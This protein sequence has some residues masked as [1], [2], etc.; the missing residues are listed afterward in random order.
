MPSVLLAMALLLA[1]DD[2][3]LE[4]YRE[5]VGPMTAVLD[6][7]PHRGWYTI[8]GGVAE[9][10]GLRG[11]VRSPRR[12]LE[13]L[14]LATGRV[15]WTA[16][17][18]WVP[19]IALEG[20]VLVAEQGDTLHSAR[21]LLVVSGEV[22]ERSQDFDLELSVHPSDWRVR[23]VAHSEDG[24]EL[25]LD[26]YVPSPVPGAM[27]GDRRRRLSLRYDPG[28]GTVAVTPVGVDP[29]ARG[30]LPPRTSRDGRV[31]VVDACEDRDGRPGREHCVR[32][33]V[34]VGSGVIM[35]SFVS[36]PGGN[37]NQWGYSSFVGGR[38]FA[39]GETPDGATPVREE[40]T[41]QERQRMGQRSIAILPCW[42]VAFDGGSGEELWRRQIRG[43]VSQVAALNPDGTPVRLGDRWKSKPQAGED[44]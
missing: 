9:P 16:G 3:F 28:A 11:Y 14:D 25:G 1:A 26:L 35:G 18:D 44:D 22:V 5:E 43:R 10:L 13:C 27:R 36:E 12:E 21:L 40:I 42:I 30:G 39:L 19:L 41:P 31:G 17:V 37:R 32:S 38:A 23:R 2:P 7:G 4:A 20:G 29:Y 34:D 33:L 8:P 15:L 6:D 24:V